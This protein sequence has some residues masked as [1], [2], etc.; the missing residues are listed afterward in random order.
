MP[1]GDEPPTRRVAPAELE[2]YLE[3]MQAGRFFEAHEE[4]EAVWH[5]S[6]SEFYHGLVILAAA[7]CK[8]ER[9]NAHGVVRNLRKARR[10]LEPYGRRSACYLGLDVRGLVNA[11]DHSLQRLQA[12]GIDPARGVTGDGAVPAAWLRELLPDLDWSWQA[13][14]LRGDEPET[15]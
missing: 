5:R 15:R 11:I 8:R 12:A 6:K 4:L 2:R 3:H 9:G 1:G 7:F 10:Y 13:E 14:D